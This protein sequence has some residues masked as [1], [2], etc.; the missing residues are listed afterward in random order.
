MKKILFAV[1]KGR[2][3]KD[4]GPKLKKAGINPEK[5]FFNENSRKIIFTTNHKNLEILKVRSFDVATFVKYGACDVGVCGRDV[6]SEFSSSEIYP[7]LDLNIGGCRL[8]LAK[9][10]D[11]LN[12]DL[13]NISHVRVASKYINLTKDFFAKKNIQAEI[14][15]LNGAMEIAPKLGLSNFIVDLVDSGKTLA[16]NNMQ[17]VETIM[18]VTSFFIANRTAFKTKNIE[19]NS[20]IKLFSD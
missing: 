8:S 19:V 15:K 2:I 4:L 13:S 16:E 12:S 7:L 3:L 11:M 10:K 5:D 6:F 14:I 18:E 20:L 1:P 9:P 17:E